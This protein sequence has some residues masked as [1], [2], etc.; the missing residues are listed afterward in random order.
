MI[1]SKKV[2]ASNN[3]VINTIHQP[4]FPGSCLTWHQLFQSA[5]KLHNIYHNDSSKLVRPKD[6]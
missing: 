1:S 2:N 5:T 4:I 3:C 6:K